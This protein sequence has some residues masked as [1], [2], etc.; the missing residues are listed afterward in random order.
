[1]WALRTLFPPVPAACQTD[2]AQCTL[3]WLILCPNFVTGEVRNKNKK[4]S[5][6]Q[7]GP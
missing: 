7:F 5:R 1:M 3:W 2:S 6:Q 4:R